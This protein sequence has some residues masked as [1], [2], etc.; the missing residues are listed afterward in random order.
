M[1][2]IVARAILLFIVLLFNQQGVAVAVAAAH[3]CQHQASAAGHTHTMTEPMHGQAVQQHSMTASDAGAA[4]DC[5]DGPE[6]AGSCN[7]GCGCAMSCAPHA[8]PL[9]LWQTRVVSEPLQATVFFY[10]ASPLSAHQQALIRPPI[11][12]V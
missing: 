7:G 5:C 9:P 4:H 8:A 1:K 2:S 10:T 11:T 3:D 12:L 6:I